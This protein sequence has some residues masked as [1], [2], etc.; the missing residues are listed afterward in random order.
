MDQKAN[1]RNKQKGKAKAKGMATKVST[2]I[3]NL[4]KA[5]T[6]D[7]KALLKSSAALVATVGAL[8][9]ARHLKKKNDEGVSNFTKYARKGRRTLDNTKDTVKRKTKDLYSYLR[10][11]IF[12][13]PEEKPEERRNSA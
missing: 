1:K 4:I 9:G 13:K 5:A 2:K 7:R 11:G 6:K 12:G 10:D 3:K 8:A